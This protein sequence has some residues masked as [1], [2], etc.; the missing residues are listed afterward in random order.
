[1]NG[2]LFSIDNFK[3]ILWYLFLVLWFYFAASLLWAE[4]K[5]YSEGATQDK[6]GE[7][8][9]KAFSKVASLTPSESSIC[10]FNPGTLTEGKYY[11]LRLN[12]FVYPRKVF[13]ISPNSE[14]TMDKLLG[15]SHIV[16]YMPA[17]FTQTGLEQALSGMPMFTKLHH[18]TYGKGGKGYVGIYS[19]IEESHR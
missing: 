8:T 14:V 18:G 7:T 6:S 13:S 2:N 1:M 12:Y 15:C 9:E 16:F 10:F 17:G 11:R 5:F 19:V 3:K 4:A